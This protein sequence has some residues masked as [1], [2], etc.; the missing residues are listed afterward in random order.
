MKRGDRVKRRRYAGNDVDVEWVYVLDVSEV[1][2]PDPDRPAYEYRI[3]T[4]SLEPPA[5]DPASDPPSR[6]VYSH[7]DIIP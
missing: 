1:H 5:D 6:T 4:V 3:V 2:R 7:T